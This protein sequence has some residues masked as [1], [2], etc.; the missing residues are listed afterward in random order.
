MALSKLLQH[1]THQTP[2]PQPRR[3]SK[4]TYG[5]FFLLQE[6]PDLDDNDGDVAATIV[7]TQKPKKHGTKQVRKGS[8]A[9][10]NKTTKVAKKHKPKKMLPLPSMVPVGDDSMFPYQSSIGDD[11]INE[12]DS[13]HVELDDDDNDDSLADEFAIATTGHD[14]LSK[15]LLLARPK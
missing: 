5:D 13:T 4:F 9:E 8:K 14:A 10:Q 2:S 12:D 6:Q 15:L 7:S 1:V 11:K 3:Q